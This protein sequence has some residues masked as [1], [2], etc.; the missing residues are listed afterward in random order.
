MVDIKIIEQFSKTIFQNCFL[1]QLANNSYQTTLNHFLSLF[2]TYISTMQ[3]IKQK[4]H[5][6]RKVSNL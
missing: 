1:K 4:V 3:L 6:G 5:Q 2:K